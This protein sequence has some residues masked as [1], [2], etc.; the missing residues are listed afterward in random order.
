MDIRTII[1]RCGGPRRISTESVRG[2]KPVARKTVYS[3]LLNG[4]PEWHWDLI[5]CLGSVTIEDIH[6]A[7]RKVISAKLS[8]RT[9]RRRTPVRAA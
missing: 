1:K 2:G 8:T 4:I 7:N 5:S 6:R 9:V 3:W